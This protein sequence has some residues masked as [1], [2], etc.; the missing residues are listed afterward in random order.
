[1]RLK[2]QWKAALPPSWASMVLARWAMSYGYVILLEVAP[3][4]FPPAS[5]L[6]EI[7]RGVV[8]LITASKENSI[9]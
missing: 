3:C 4:P 6:F 5:L 9:E 7:F 8:S 1:M 2:A